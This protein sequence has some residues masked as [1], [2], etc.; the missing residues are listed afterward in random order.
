[1]NKTIKDIIDVIKNY[2]CERSDATYKLLESATESTTLESID[3][4]DNLD[5][6]ELVIDLE[7]EFGIEF[8]ACVDGHEWKTLGDVVRTVNDTSLHLPPWD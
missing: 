2:W 4:I 1:M 6:V 7:N 8:D 5:K 3:I